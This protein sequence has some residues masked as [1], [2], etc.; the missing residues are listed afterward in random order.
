MPLII[1]EK[2]IKT[3]KVKGR[4]LMIIED[5]RKLTFQIYS[6]DHVTEFKLPKE[7]DIPI[8]DVFSLS[9]LTYR[10][11]N[12]RAFGNLQRL[13][14]LI[15]N[16]KKKKV[17]SLAHSE[18]LKGAY[19]NLKIPKY[20]K[21]ILDKLS[22]KLVHLPKEPEKRLTYLSEKKPVL[23][24]TVSCKLLKT[25]VPINRCR[26]CRFGICKF[27]T[28]GKRQILKSVICMLG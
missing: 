8:D 17:F 27:E 12:I 11:W 6:F 10:N 18:L 5:R 16:V 21:A 1:D 9:G 28:L 25:H 13:Y 7:F 24:L 20:I 22:S 3:F 26:F 14:V 23:T 19:I 4:T 15:S 2:T